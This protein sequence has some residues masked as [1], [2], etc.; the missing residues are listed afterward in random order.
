MN[1][2]NLENQI[3]K[4]E[5]ATGA[6]LV[7]FV[8]DKQLYSDPHTDLYLFWIALTVYAFVYQDFYIYV[9]LGLS[10]LAVLGLFVYQNFL[11][12]NDKKIIENL[13]KETKLTFLD[14]GLSETKSRNGILL[15]ISKRHKKIYVLFDVGINKSLNTKDHHLIVENFSKH[16]QTE[17]LDKGVLNGIESMQNF[18]ISK[19]IKFDNTQNE[20]SNEIRD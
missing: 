13:E 17:G 19:E 20:L 1:K 11:G 15:Y 2:E 7:V 4:F 18:L 9:F 10:L 8:S 14:E 16:I 5:Q 12:A 6:E 3:E